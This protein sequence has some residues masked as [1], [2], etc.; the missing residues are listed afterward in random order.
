VSV[1]G[2]KGADDGI[3]VAVVQ[4]SFTGGACAYADPLAINK[5][6]DNANNSR[7]APDLCDFVMNIPVFPMSVFDKAPDIQHLQVSSA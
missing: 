2:G 5:A 7:A 1:N 6:P 3:T 4:L